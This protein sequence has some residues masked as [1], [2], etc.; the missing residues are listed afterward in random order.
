MFGLAKRIEEIYL[1]GRDETILLDRH[2]SALH[3]IQRLRDEAH[4]FAITH[5]RQLRARSSISSQLDTI[6]GIGEKRKH[7]LLRHFK[8]V[9]QLRSASIRR[10]AG[11]RW[12]EPASKAE[13]VHAFFH[14]AQDAAAV[15]GAG[16]D[17]GEHAGMVEAVERLKPTKRLKR[18]KRLAQT[19]RL[20]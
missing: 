12:N 5:H 13:A 8:T 18:Q 17:S 1:P 19:N 14:G 7:A 6:A 16:G 9:E 3:L 2:S 11:G 4:R 20:K 10:A 15:D